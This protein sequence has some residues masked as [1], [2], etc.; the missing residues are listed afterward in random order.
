M[1]NKENTIF[2]WDIKHFDVVPNANG[3]ENVITRI[4]WEYK[5]SYTDNNGTPYSQLIYG[6]ADINAPDP[7]SFVPFSQISFEQATNWLH[8][9]LNVPDLQNTITVLMNNRIN[10]PVITMSVP[11]TNTSTNT[12]DTT[13]TNTNDTTTTNTNDTTT[14]NTNDTTTTNTNDTTTNTNDT[15]TN[16]NDIT[17]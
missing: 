11:W 6:V 14:T 8:K 4:H 1:A 16:T 15:T 12:N 3:M 10:P 9:V 13:T 17:L 5:G 2:S 7:M